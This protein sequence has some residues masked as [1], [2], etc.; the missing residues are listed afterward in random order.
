LNDWLDRSGETGG[1]G[2]GCLCGFK[3]PQDFVVAFGPQQ[4]FVE[5]PHVLELLAEQLAGSDG[6][7]TALPNAMAAIST[8][9]VA[10]VSFRP[11]KIISHSSKTRTT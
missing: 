6:D 10:T 1:D 3:Q 8:T 11:R 9:D 7:A 5:G 4:H 2:S